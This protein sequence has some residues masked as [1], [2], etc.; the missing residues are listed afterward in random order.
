[1]SGLSACSGSVLLP[2]YQQDTSSCT[3]ARN[4]T[5]PSSLPTGAG[6]EYCHNQSATG[7]SLRIQMDSLCEFVQTSADSEKCR[8]TKLQKPN[9]GK[10]RENTDETV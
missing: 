10:E 5:N 3:H 7:I 9:P 8:P 2:C 4:V 1:M 6:F